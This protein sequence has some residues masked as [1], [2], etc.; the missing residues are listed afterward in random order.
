MTS[1]SDYRVV[2][3]FSALFG[4]VLVFLGSIALLFLTCMLLAA[5]L[6]RL[7]LPP[8]LG[9]LLAGILLGPSV[10]NLLDDGLLAISGSLRKIALLII[11]ARAGLTLRRSDLKKVGRPALLMCFVPALCE[12]AAVTL[13]G[14]YFLDISRLE[15]AILGSVLAAVSPAVVVPQMLRLMEEGWGTERC[16]PQLILAGASMDDIVVIVLFTAFTGLAQGSGVSGWQL[17]AVPVSV[18]TGL[19]GGMLAGL[20][21]TLLLRRWKPEGLRLCLVFLSVAFLLAAL[22]D[23][24]VVPFSGLLAVMA[25]A[26]LLQQRQPEAGDA[27]QR[28]LSQLWVPA[29]MLLFALVGAAVDLHYAGQMGAG[30]LALLGLALLCR[31]LGVALCLLRTPLRPKERLFCMIAYLPKA[32]VQAAVGGVPLAMGLACG[33]LVL[34]GAV[35]AILLTAPLGAIGMAC[36]YRHLLTQDTSV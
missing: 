11:L 32:T 24:G 34:T 18:V 15:A 21:L 16:I 27:L 19:A 25:A 14:P 31:M 10:L 33:Q 5:L 13:L 22:E 6:Q 4:G 20:V 8:L 2:G 9:M 3:F 1:V 23:W 12:L 29:Q 7:H 36:T 26:N 28:Q 30:M 17:A 35:A